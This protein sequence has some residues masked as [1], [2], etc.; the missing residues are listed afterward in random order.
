MAA[1]YLAMCRFRMVLAASAL[2]NPGS[3]LIESALGFPFGTASRYA[4]A[5]VCVT[6]WITHRSCSVGRRFSRFRE[7]VTSLD[8]APS[9]MAVQERR[10]MR[11]NIWKCWVLLGLGATWLAA[12]IGPGPGG[13]GYPGGGGLGMPVPRRSKKPPKSVAQD[14]LQEYKGALK[15]LSETTIE[16][17]TAETGVVKFRRDNKTE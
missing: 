3:D 8:P 11:D 14:L 13:L 4:R 16:L 6:L 10:R 1:R 17:E 9:E 2:S 5:N 7:F 12:Q 15:S